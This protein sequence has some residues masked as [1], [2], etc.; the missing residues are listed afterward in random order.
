MAAIAAGRAGVPPDVNWRGGPL[1]ARVFRPL[2]RLPEP[3]FLALLRPVQ[4]VYERSDGR[5]GARVTGL[6]VLLLR[7]R[8]RRTGRVRTAALVYASDG[9]RVAVVGSKV[10][11]RHAPLWFRNLEAEPRA[12]VQV[13]RAR[14]AVTA[15]V[16][17]GPEREMWWRRALRLWPF[18]RYQRRTDRT[19]PVVVL[20]PAN[21]RD[22]LEE[23]ER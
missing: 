7:T 15:R 5:V 18:D 16:V 11:D 17:E 20:E 23:S 9:R 21:G 12:E 19:F 10:G 4:V 13:G 22:R 14:W 3:A 6:P 2:S 1:R 8:G